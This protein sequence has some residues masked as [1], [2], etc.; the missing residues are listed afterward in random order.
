MAF[1]EV[2]VLRKRVFHPEEPFMQKWN[3]IFLVLSAV[4]LSLDLFFFYDLGID[5]RRKCLRMD[6]K[7]ERVLVILSSAVDFFFITGVVFQFRTGFFA[8]STRIF[9]AGILVE[10]SWEIARRYLLS[11]FLIDVLATLPLPQVAILLIIPRMGGSRI[12]NTINLLKFIVLFQFVPKIYRFYQLYKATV[13]SSHNHSR[14]AEFTLFLYICAG[15]VSGSFWYLFSIEREMDCWRGACGSHTGCSS[16]KLYCSEYFGNAKDTN[17]F[18]RF[19]DI[20]C[21]ADIQGRSPFDFGVFIDAHNSGILESTSLWRKLFYCSWWA[22]QNLSTLG[23]NLKTSTDTLEICFAVCIFVG[24]V[25][26]FSFVIG[27]IQAVMLSST[28]RAET[29]KMKWQDVEHWMDTYSLPPTLRKRV[30]RHEQYKWKQIKGLDV[31]NLLQNFPKSLRS[32]IKRHLCWSLLLRVPMFEKMDEQVLDAMCDRLKPAL[33]TEESNI[34]R[35]G[36]PVDEMLFI[37]RGK[38]RT[39]TKNWERTGFFN[40][41]YLKAGD[42]CGE[43][44]LTWALDPH[45]SYLPISTRTV[46]TRTEVEGFALMADDL[47]YVVSQIRQLHSKQLR[48]T[49]RYYSQQWRTWAACFIQAAW[50]RYSKKKLEES[51]RQE[52]DRLQDALAKT[53]GNSLS[54]GATIYASRFAANALRAIRRSGTRKGRLHERVPPML[55]NLQKPA[56]PDFASEER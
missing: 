43:E 8:C 38:L 18:N 53:S 50:R 56:E 12:S 54:L 7:L 47:K 42:Y 22:L 21:P 44:L 11:Y 23:Q 34:V 6:V 33:Y 36:D 26:L 25:L 17:E 30:K 5:N 32:D 40:S 39:M 45:S 16:E 24:G 31:E 35:E 19:L 46:Q 49:F 2:V 4:A 52:E 27:I 1:W 10:D 9:D 37:M 55:L 14:I 51:L 15:H 28:M 41:A 29:M 20:A 3:K 48:L 13:K